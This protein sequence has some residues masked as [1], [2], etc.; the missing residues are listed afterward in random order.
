MYPHQIYRNKVIGVGCGFRGLNESEQ[1]NYNRWIKKYSTV[2]GT[3]RS[4]SES[5]VRDLTAQDFQ[6]E[7]QRILD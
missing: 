6:A 7:K 3:L 4:H 5:I 1:K 2:L